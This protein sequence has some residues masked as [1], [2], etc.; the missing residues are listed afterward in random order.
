[1]RPVRESGVVFGSEIMKKA[2]TS[3]APFCSWWAGIANGSPSQSASRPRQHDEAQA[4]E[5]ECAQRGTAPLPGRYPRMITRHHECND[6]EVG[7]VEDVLGAHTYE[8]L[9]GNR[10]QGGERGDRD[11]VGAE[12]QGQ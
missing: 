7:R 1:M 11:E 8:E 10:N 5:G 3:N 2:N 9:A 12:Q 6:C 4:G